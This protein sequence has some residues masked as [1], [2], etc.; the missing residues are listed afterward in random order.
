MSARVARWVCDE[1]ATLPVRVSSD[2][3][4][5][6]RCARQCDLPSVGFLRCSASSTDRGVL[7]PLCRTPTSSAGTT[8][9]RPRRSTS[10]GC[11][12]GS[13]SSS[14]STSRSALRD[15][16]AVCPGRQHRRGWRTEEARVTAERS[17]PWETVEAGGGRGPAPGAVSCYCWAGSVELPVSSQRLVAFPCSM[18]ARSGRMCP[19]SRVPVA[20]EGRGACR[21]EMRAVGALAAELLRGAGRGLDA[22]PSSTTTCG[23]RTP[24]TGVRSPT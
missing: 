13:T 20:G 8:T 1:A 23:R 16:A 10:S 6:A 12:A 4:V 18:T 19:V 5:D 17:C 22:A 2:G 11:R 9:A 24:S 15:A 21:G 14:G 3:P 7:V